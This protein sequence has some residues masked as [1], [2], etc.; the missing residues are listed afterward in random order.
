[1]TN[2]R[3]FPCGILILRMLNYLMYMSYGKR[4][5]KLTAGTGS[6]STQI[7]FEGITVK[8][9]LDIGY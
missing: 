2:K 9:N 1:V 3:E 5:W 4:E 8:H 7:I 6:F